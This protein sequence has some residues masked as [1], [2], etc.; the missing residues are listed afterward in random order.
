MG[1]V[2]EVPNRVTIASPVITVNDEAS[3][4]EEVEDADD[5]M[6]GDIWTDDQLARLEKENPRKHRDILRKRQANAENSALMETLRKGLK[7]CRYADAEELPPR[8]NDLIGKTFKLNSCGAGQRKSARDKTVRIKGFYVPRD[9]SGPLDVFFVPSVEE[10]VYNT[11]VFGN[12]VVNVER[13]DN[14][15][16]EA[17]GWLGE[18]LGE[19]EE[20]GRQSDSWGRHSGRLLHCCPYRPNGE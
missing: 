17:D 1:G 5:H 19:M 11:T 18:I 10:Q 16:R 14:S 12:V 9:R 15:A 8:V 13:H 2:D 20:A 7:D 3:E 6:K 4:L